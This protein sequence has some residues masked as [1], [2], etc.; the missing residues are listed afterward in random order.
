M[1]ATMDPL[2]TLGLTLV[3]GLKGPIIEVVFV[4]Q[5]KA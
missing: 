2:R 1:P 4:V 5:P 3:S